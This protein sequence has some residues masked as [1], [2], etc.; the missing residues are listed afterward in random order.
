MGIKLQDHQEAVL[1]YFI[2]DKFARGLLLF[3]G[4]GSGKTLT[5]IA[6]SER[7]KYFKEVILI[8]PKSLHDK[9]RLY[10]F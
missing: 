8:A 9:F 2:A 1:E 5:A 3:H 10:P 4:T 7:F 6:I